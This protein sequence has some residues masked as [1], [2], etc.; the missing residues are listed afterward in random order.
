MTGFV[1]FIQCGERVKIGWSRDPKKRLV[2]IQC[3]NGAPCILL[4]AVAGTLDQE[5][6]IHDLLRPW[7]L[8]GE[9]FDGTA[10][11]VAAA[12]DHFGGLNPPDAPRQR[13]P[14][15]RTKLAARLWQS[16]FRMTDVATALRID[17]AN[18][19]RWARTGIPAERVCAVEAMT[20]IPRHELR[21]D[22][23]EAA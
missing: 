15:L 8:S 6:E 20:G 17:K 11:P 22:L 7:R 2:K 12:C 23:Y 19:S 1:Y 21:P 9:W 14:I 16:G 10:A 5:A 18:L 4:G 3:D 13:R